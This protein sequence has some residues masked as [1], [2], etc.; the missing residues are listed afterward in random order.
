MMKRITGLVVFLILIV[1]LDLAVSQSPIGAPRT[2]AL[3][4]DLFEELMKSWDLKLTEIKKKKETE[5]VFI[6][7]EQIVTLNPDFLLV[8][9][10]DLSLIL[11][12]VPGSKAY[13]KKQWDSLPASKKQK[14]S[15][16][17]EEN[18]WDMALRLKSK[19]NG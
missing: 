4:E 13:L 1:P 15:S 5:G 6:L 2:P 7:A 12:E 10:E 17:L 19:G 3:T 8:L 9:A 16:S 11:K 18:L 14:L